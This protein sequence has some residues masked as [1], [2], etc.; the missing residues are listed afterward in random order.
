M[1][2][3]QPSNKNMIDCV[4]DVRLGGNVHIG[5]HV[6]NEIII[7][8]PLTRSGYIIDSA[9]MFFVSLLFPGWALVSLVIVAKNSKPT[10]S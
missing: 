1:Y 9:V 7:H 2:Y 6:T 10:L 4:G 8:A 3:S 5:G